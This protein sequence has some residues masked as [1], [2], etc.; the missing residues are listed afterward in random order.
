MPAL[1]SSNIIS[2]ENKTMAHT[3]IIFSHKKCHPCEIN[4]YMMMVN[5]KQ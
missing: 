1:D 2:E 5:E 4:K 3:L